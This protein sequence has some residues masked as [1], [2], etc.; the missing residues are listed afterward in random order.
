[1]LKTA[2]PRHFYCNQAS[3]VTREVNIQVDIQLP[4]TG[5]PAIFRWIQMDG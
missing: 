3:P 2:P 5:Y 4:L 1:M